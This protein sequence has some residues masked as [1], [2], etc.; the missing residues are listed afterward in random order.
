MDN[1]LR[2]TH[3]AN[4]TRIAWAVQGQGPVMVRAAHWMT[5]VE[6]DLQ[7]PLWRP[8][9]E[10]L[11]RSVRLVR[12]DERGCGASG[13]D[14]TAP[15]LDSAVEE[16]AAVVQACG[17]ERV[18][19]LGVSGGAAAALAYAVRHPE[20][21]SQLV[22]LGG[23]L[24]GLLQQDPSA[25][26]LALHEAQLQLM[27]LG[28]GRRHPAVQQFFT[29]QLVPDASPEQA[30]A[31]N[32]QQRLSCDGAQAAALLHAR[33]SL[34]VR[35]LAPLVRV[36]TLV[37]HAQGDLMVAPERGRDLAAAIPGARF[38]TLA[39]RNHVPLPGDGG[40]DRFCQALAGFVRDRALPSLSPRERALAE[41]VVQ[42]L[43]IA[44]IAA[45]LGR[46][47][48]TVRNAL[49]ALYARLGVEGR[50]Q[51]M[52]WLRDSGLV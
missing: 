24:C 29:T 48:K 32:E 22:L 40:F 30:A 50:P 27:R 10:R 34:D 38:E 47:E 52:A 37:L 33:A 49:S 4:G 9:L 20:R 6:H 15:G 21:V 28:W 13:R 1:S 51:A 43:D 2:F 14:G 18:A 42:G 46:A 5:H 3:L 16:L 26:T 12:Y 8:W 31:L 35:A 41:L 7:S 36:P 23:Y 25:E 19:L 11:G 44:Q 39:T 17:A 45:R